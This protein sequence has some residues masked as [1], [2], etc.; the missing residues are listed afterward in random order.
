MSRAS[1]AADEENM[2]AGAS[3]HFSPSF[4]R[5]ASCW[6]C[7]V[8]LVCVCLFFGMFFVGVV[9]VFCFQRPI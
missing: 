9:A 7:F 8:W 2:R 5:M 3:F 4:P 1:K 6:F